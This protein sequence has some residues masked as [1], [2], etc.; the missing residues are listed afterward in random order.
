MEAFKVF[1]PDGIF[2]STIGLFILVI[3][4]IISIPHFKKLTKFKLVSYGILILLCSGMI[5]GGIDLI[6]HELDWIQEDL[7][8]PDFRIYLINTAF[9]LSKFIVPFTFSAIG[10]FMIVKA[11]DIKMKV[12]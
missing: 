5:L 1:V 3:V 9:M 8:T 4:F 10:S 2:Y 12:E 7:K 6:L 11:L